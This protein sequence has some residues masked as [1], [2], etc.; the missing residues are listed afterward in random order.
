MIAAIRSA[1]LELVPL[2][3]EFLD[4]ALAGD[5]REAS[6]ILGARVPD[7]W[8]DLRDTQTLFLERLRAEPA[9]APWAMR[10]LVLRAER[11]MVGHIG[12]HCAPTSDG[13]ELAYAVF[14]PDRRRGYAREACRAFMD[15]A[16]AEHGVGR[17]VLRIAPDNVAS[18]RLA[19]ALSGQQGDERQ[20]RRG[21]EP[22]AERE[23]QR[24]TPAG[25]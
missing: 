18:L 5:A 25:G 6:R 24:P 16:R 13:V 20:P 3:P 10:A 17:F 21:S 1:R 14:A 11:R 15:W 12:C 8:P 23:R 22:V 19:R 2:P 7:D 9:L 4:A